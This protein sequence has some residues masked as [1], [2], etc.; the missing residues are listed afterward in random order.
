MFITV[1][2]GSGTTNEAANWVRAA[3]ITN[4]CGF[5]YWEVGNECYYGNE[6][7]YNTNSP[8]IDHDPWTYAMR[9]RDYYNAMKAVDPTIRIGIVA[10]PGEDYIVNNTDHPAVNPRT[11]VT[12]YGWT[13]VLLATLNSLG[14]MPDFLVHH[15]YPEQG[16]D[17]D[18]DLLQATYNWAGRRKGFTAAA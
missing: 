10:V 6:T 1:N 16:L 13:P 3:N 2:Y 8:Y 9:F 7:D 12:H 18:A 14:V 15:F 17:D 4:H 5:K 11:G